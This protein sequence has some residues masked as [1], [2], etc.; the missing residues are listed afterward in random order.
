MHALVKQL[1]KWFIAIPAWIYKCF[2]QIH[3]KQMSGHFLNIYIFFNRS[4]HI[5]Q[6]T[7][8][9][10]VC[11]GQ[12]FRSGLVCVRT[13]TRKL[14]TVTVKD[15][16][17]R[18]PAARQQ[19]LVRSLTCRKSGLT[20]NNGCFVHLR[21]RLHTSLQ[22]LHLPQARH[23]TLV[24]ANLCMYHISISPISYCH[25]ILLKKTNKEYVK[26]NMTPLKG[27][28]AKEPRALFPTLKVVLKR[29]FL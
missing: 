21:V 3:I 4:I 10:N 23:L 16:D 19:W 14:R 22:Q 12:N 20:Q 1:F 9:L 18:A 6:H 7:L 17:V 26:Y 28:N 11:E 13:H 24:N 25:F 27:D 29:W 8:L 2:G 15:A 5:L